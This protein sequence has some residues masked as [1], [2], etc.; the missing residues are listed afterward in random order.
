MKTVLIVDDDS[1][2]QTLLQDALHQFVT[3][4][5]DLAGDGEEALE[6]VRH[7]LPDLI[8]LDMMLP[9][10]SGN[11]LFYE[12]KKLMMPKTFL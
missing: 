9:R 8:I 6:H 5:V 4:N 12:L 2:I 11:A 3:R 7:K 10:M 1:D